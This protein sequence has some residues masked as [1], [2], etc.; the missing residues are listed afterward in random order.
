M[1]LG[2]GM[3][4]NSQPDFAASDSGLVTKALVRAADR[5]NVTNRVLARIIGVSDA[6]VSRMKKG[7]YPLEA[8]Q[9]PFQLAVLFL[10]LYRSLDALTGGDDD[11]SAR[12]LAN[13]NTALDGVPIA[14]VQ[15][16]SGL[17]NVVSYLDARRA[18]V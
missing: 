4:A 18:V 6:T 9:K 10:R 1:N 3:P 13:R 11:V 8:G 2:D 17:M 7:E 16:V 12:W 14:L 15:S 5:L